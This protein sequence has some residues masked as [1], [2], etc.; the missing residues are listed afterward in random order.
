MGGD[1]LLM[2]ASKAL[3]FVGC[4][5]VKIE[6][7]LWTTGSMIQSDPFRFPIE[8]FGA[9]TANK[10]FEYDCHDHISSPFSINA[11]QGKHNFCPFATRLPIILLLS[12]LDHLHWKPLSFIQLGSPSLQFL[13]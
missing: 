5:G 3:Q 13:L 4:L 11:S 12:S 6:R 10:D 8:Q 1:A 2:L 7:W 9:E